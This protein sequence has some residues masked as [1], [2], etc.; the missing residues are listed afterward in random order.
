MKILFIFLLLLL[1][2]FVNHS[3]VVEPDAVNP[4][5]ED[6]YSILNLSGTG[7]ARNVFDLAIKGLKKLESNGKLQNPDIL[8]IA[9]YSQSS[10]K[11]RFY[12]IDLKNKK[13]LFNTLVAHGRKT[14]EEFAKYFSNEVGSLK[15]S[16][17]FY[18]TEQP[19]TGSHT[20]FSLM[21][22]G[23]EKG[24]NDLAAKREIIVHGAEYATENFVKKYGRLG[25]SLGC[26][27]LPPEMVKEV[28]EHIKGGT[29]LFLYNPD[30]Q[31]IKTSSLLN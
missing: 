14:G 3:S 13:L 29:C 9:D 24:I 17:G 27:A 15:S 7:L 5:L 31:Y 4:G 12:V 11:K 22:E 25:R 18:I 8:T 28:I 10:N 19:I 2:P 20:G 1:L 6:I 30:K 21:I 26:P 23:V 16:L